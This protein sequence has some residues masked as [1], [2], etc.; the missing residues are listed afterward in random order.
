MKRL[1][2]LLAGPEAY[3]L[4]VSVAMYF[5]ASGNTPPTEAGNQAVEKWW[6]I[7][8]LALV[9]ATF[10]ILLLHRNGSAAG[11]LVR[12]NLTCIAG[13][14]VSVHLI[15]GAI[16]YGDSRNSGVGMGYV[17][18]IIFGMFSL[19]ASNVFAAGGLWIARRK[20]KRPDGGSTVRPSE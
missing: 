18:S 16:D 13:L 17:M 9:P 10:F 14:I 4:L 6:F 20:R 1:R 7:L 19:F 12:I 11:L 2:M 8:P 3:W 5:L 15:T